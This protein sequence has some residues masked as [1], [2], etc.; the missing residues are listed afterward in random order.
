MAF[1]I[2][3]I[4]D[5]HKPRAKVTIEQTDGQGNP[6]PGREWTEN[7]DTQQK[8]WPQ[9]K[10]RFKDRVQADNTKAQAVTD[11]TDEAN[12]EGITNMS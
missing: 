5:A 11:L 6:I 4:R 9:L 8:D 12:N 10:Q 1:R 2:K 7:F 3:T